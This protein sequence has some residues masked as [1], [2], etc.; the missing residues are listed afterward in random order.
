M[1]RQKHMWRLI[2]TRGISDSD[3]DADHDEV[4][5][6]VKWPWQYRKALKEGIKKRDELMQTE[7][8][9]NLR[10]RNFKIAWI[11]RLPP[12]KKKY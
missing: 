9:K 8:A 3:S 6:G 1:W 7:R 10:Y 11:W 4:M 2:W 5:L 12:Y